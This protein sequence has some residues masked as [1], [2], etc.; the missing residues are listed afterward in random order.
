MNR[1]ILPCVCIACVL[2][3]AVTWSV[4]WLAAA[5]VALLAWMIRVPED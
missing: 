3:A 2:A 1:V 5:W 4:Y